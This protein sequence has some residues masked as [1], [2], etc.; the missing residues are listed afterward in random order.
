M[1]IRYSKIENKNK[2]EIV[3]L[4]SFPCKYGKC[5]FCNYIEDN[6]TDE[7][8]IDKVNLE[9]LQEVTG[10]FGA[11]EVINSGSV[12]ELPIKTLERIREVVY[13][14]NIKLLYFEIYY[15]YKNRLDEIREFF[16]GVDIRFRM[17]MET[18]DNN[19][20]INSYGKNFKIDTPE[21]EELSKKLYSV[22][23]LI[24][25]KGQTKE[26]IKKDI[27]LGLKYFKSITVNIFINNG[28]EVERD[29]ELVKWFV[30]NYNQL[31]EDPR[32]ELLIDNKDLGV[33]E[34]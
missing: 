17:G 14:K 26:M 13:N 2:R 20:R 32:V 1:G 9:T 30:E 12:F 27:E 7:L 23:L 15:G 22:C 5:K 8:E 6:S 11:L 28:T 25:V 34:Q 3:L 10:E 31:Q 29:E 24:C 18:F 21:I 33:F 4:K 16:K 19:F